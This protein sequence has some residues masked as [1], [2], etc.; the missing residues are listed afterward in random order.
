M[1]V[2]RRAVIVIFGLGLTASLL[3]WLLSDNQIAPNV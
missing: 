3:F 2:W 1:Q